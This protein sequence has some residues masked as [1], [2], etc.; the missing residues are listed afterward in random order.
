M[1]SLHP[2]TKFILVFVISGLSVLLDQAFSL[3]ALALG[4]VFLFLAAWPSRSW[5]KGFFLLVST[6]V[7]GIMI[8]QGLFY[9]DFPRTIV[10]C[11]VPPS[12]TFPGLCFIKEGF[13]YGFIQ[14]L[15]FVAALSAGAYLINSTSTEMLF[16][17]VGAL[18]LP[19]GLS[20]MAAASV[21]ALPRLA[22]DLHLVRQALR[23]RGYRPFRRGLIYTL[24]TEMAVVYPLL[25]RAIRD[26]RA[27]ADT[28]LTRG[29]DPLAPAKNYF[30]PPW[31]RMER[32]L[33]LVL[34]GLLLAIFLGKILF[35]AYLQGV[36]Y[37]EV[38]R[39]FYAFFRKYV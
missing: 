12:E 6:T 21:R 1:K 15:R 26:S 17:A 2:Y 33:S 13:R 14:S 25:V 38:L 4:S 29:F 30:L 35:W 28:L 39:P 20:L 16:R 19:R 9:Q 24:R 27:L 36:F 7:W 22:E 5:L 34:M 32:A 3:M 11:L 10:F 37:A 23:L 8:S 18:P 31:P